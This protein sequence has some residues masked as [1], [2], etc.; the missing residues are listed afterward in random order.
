[1][2]GE[3]RW[4]EEIVDGGFPESPDPE[5]VTEEPVQERTEKETIFGEETAEEPF[6]D[7]GKGMDEPR[8]QAEPPFEETPYQE[9]PEEAMEEELLEPPE[10]SDDA[11]P[12]RFSGDFDSDEA[13]TPPP[14]TEEREDGQSR[15][16]GSALIVLIIG[17]LLFLA[18]F[19]LLFLNEGEAVLRHKALKAGTGE[20]LT[21]SANRVDPANNGKLIYV[22]G[23]AAAAGALNDGPAQAIGQRPILV[24]P[25]RVDP[26]NEGRLVQVSGRAESGAYI[27]DREFGISVKAIKLERRV[28]MY[29][30]NEENLPGAPPAY[31]KIWSIRPIQSS[32]FRQPQGHANPGVIDYRSFRW[33]SPRVSLGAFT[34]PNAI[35][36]EI[37]SYESF[38][39]LGPM[40]D[41]PHNIR[42]RLTFYN[43]GFYMGRDPHQPEI[44]DLRIEYRIVRNAG[45]TVTA[46][47]QG[48]SF[49]PH[50]T[51]TGE[52]ILRVAVGQGDFSEPLRAISAVSAE[53]VIKL[54]RQ[55]QIYQWNEVNAHKT[56]N[57]AGDSGEAEGGAAYEKVW[58]DRIIEADRFRQKVNPPNQETMPVK[59]ETFLAPKVTLGA[60][61]L[62]RRMVDQMNQF[63]PLPVDVISANLPREL[64]GAAKIHN[65]GYYI[66]ADP[67]NP[68][69]NDLKITYSVVRPDRVSIVAQQQG[70][71]FAPYKTENGEV[72]VFAAGTRTAG[73]MFASARSANG[74][75]TWLFRAGGFLL[76]FMGLYMILAPLISAR[77]TL[78]LV[79]R[80]EKTEAKKV[81]LFLAA[82]FVLLTAG[83]AW[84]FFRPLIGGMLISVGFILAGVG[85]LMREPARAGA[86]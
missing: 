9:T 85:L 78:P 38:R 46:Q 60:F 81:T 66:G 36:K 80:I 2:A 51:Q 64:Q 30:W 68:N 37:D 83:A 1:M 33:V 35:V 10:T 19:P 63:E 27:P 84:I 50:R 75:H 79:G 34:L 54:R 58:S 52:E 8:D 55:V 17:I 16:R 24:S 82:A 76:M 29:Q 74:L 61:E 72:E 32:R 41:P 49:A 18:A 44:G 67:R 6:Q 14:D 42:D 7:S 43:G 56:D 69:V 77:D 21:I 71:T 3:D 11:A 5:E 45:V 23:V 86:A 73:E 48:H 13:Q 28:L 59:D 65:G 31:E 12:A 57:G 47:Q 15:L 4:E 62:P 53:N 22:T 70:N 25:N 40:A 20:V 26:A 39:I